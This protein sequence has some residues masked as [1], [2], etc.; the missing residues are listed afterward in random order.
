MKI[1]LIIKLIS[2][3]FWYRENQPV[4]HLWR[5]EL[6]SHKLHLSYAQPRK[7]KMKLQKTCSTSC[8]FCARLTAGDFQLSCASNSPSNCIVQC[9][10]ISH[11][12][13]KARPCLEIELCG[14]PMAAMANFLSTAL[15]AWIVPLLRTCILK[16]PIRKVITNEKSARS[17]S[18]QLANGENC[19]T[20][21]SCNNTPHVAMAKNLESAERLR[22]RD[23]YPPLVTA[24]IFITSGQRQA[25]ASLIS[26]RSRNVK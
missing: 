6:V 17:A 10:I 4:F 9:A 20:Q 3:Q 14:S 8:S 18:R 5:L 26:S 16:F 2:N 12:A 21:T 15:E 25:A 22:L 19:A 1:H 23:I 7:A 24:P 11:T 13:N